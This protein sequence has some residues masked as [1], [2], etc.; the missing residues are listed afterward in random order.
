MYVSLFCNFGMQT[1]Q[2]FSGFCSHSVF[3]YFVG[4]AY[5]SRAYQLGKSELQ[6]SSQVRL[7]LCLHSQPL[8]EIAAA[9]W[10][11][12]FSWWIM[13]AK[14]ASLSNTSTFKIYIKSYKLTLIG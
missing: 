7:T 3:L 13:E 2:N 5:L 10:S 8:E 11:V 4:S 1:R 14:E 12:F 6:T 9:T